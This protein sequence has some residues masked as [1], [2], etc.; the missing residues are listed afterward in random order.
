MRVT[1][2]RFARLP[3][4][5][6]PTLG[7][8]RR[9]SKVIVLLAIVLA[10]IELA[11]TGCRAPEEAPVDAA[12]IAEPSLLAD[13]GGRLRHV[14]IS[15]NSARR[16]ALRNAELV[17]N[18]VN[19][20]PEDT[21]ILLLVNDPGA[22]EIA[23][24]GWPQ[25]LDVAELPNDNSIT[26]WTQD[27][28]LVLDGPGG[29]TLLASKTF[30]RAGDSL[31][32][33]KIAERTGYRLVVSELDFEGGNIVSDSENILIGANTIR[34]NAVELGL[35]EAEVV[36]RFQDELGRAVLVVG[37]V[38]QPVAHIDMMLTPLGDGR[39]A[40]AD[41]AEGARIATEALRTE[42]DA[43]ADFERYCEEYFFGHPAIREVTGKGGQAFSPPDVSGK[44]GDMIALS[45]AIAPIL[46]GIATSLEG[47]GYR[48]ERIPFL[49]G[50]PESNDQSDPDEST[51]AAYPMLTYNN[52]LIERTVGSAVVYLPRYGWAVMDAAA[53]A[54]WEHI[55]FEPRPIDGLTIS[56]MY[57]GALRCAVKVLER[58]DFV[59]Q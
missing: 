27:P 40:L 18:I 39:I 29:P 37:P 57:G 49:F 47:Y 30:E 52:V 35:G 59:P 14:A 16:A 12:P 5:V 43:V 1:S 9:W 21:S 3:R 28:F 56:A 41:A 42:P 22:F 50:G 25:R 32:A 23:A 8:P 6:L 7:Q 10:P 13:T 51:R 20:L 54:A 2:S 4:M 19:G 26:I 38:P 45:R 11:T 34:Y 53:A 48:V 44:T 31:M 36:R 15:V 55:G 33:T 17:T 46:D 24:D 58:A